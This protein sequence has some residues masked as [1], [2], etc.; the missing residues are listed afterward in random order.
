MEHRTVADC[1]GEKSSKKQKYSSGQLGEDHTV[2][3]CELLHKFEPEQLLLWDD[4][5]RFD[6]K[7]MSCEEYT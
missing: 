5:K 6:K 1:H 7:L 3:S 4:E 2:H